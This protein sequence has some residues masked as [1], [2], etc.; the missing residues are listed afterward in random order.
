MA[1][2]NNFVLL[3][4]SPLQP[5]TKATQAQ[6]HA[7]ISSSPAL[8][9]LSQLLSRKSCTTSTTMGRGPLPQDAVVSFK[10]ASSLLQDSQSADDSHHTAGNGDNGAEASPVVPSAEEPIMKKARRPAKDKE[11]IKGKKSK[12][13]ATKA[14]SARRTSKSLLGSAD[15]DPVT[16]PRDKKSREPAQTHIEGSKVTKIG[17]VNGPL[18]DSKLKSK[19]KNSSEIGKKST[20]PLV[21]VKEAAP[22]ACSEPVDLCLD[23]TIRRRSDWTPVKDTGDGSTMSKDESAHTRAPLDQGTP[24]TSK[25]SN[26]F[27]NLLEDYGYDHTSASVKETSEVSRT[28]TGEALTKRRKVEV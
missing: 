15:I 5:V 4:S 13:S 14:T 2:A 8:P 25:C 1:A 11:P 9:S 24:A 3:S 28:P 10:S 23:G 16:R 27:E 20:K 21:E 6:Q 7:S 18:G 19:A 22:F 26:Y 12:A 17:S